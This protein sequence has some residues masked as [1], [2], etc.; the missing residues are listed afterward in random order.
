MIYNDMII[1]PT[2]VWNKHSSYIRRPPKGGSQ[3][4]ENDYILVV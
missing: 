2:G 1:G 3:K 4:A